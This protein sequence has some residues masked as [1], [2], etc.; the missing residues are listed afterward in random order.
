MWPPP[1]LSLSRSCSTPI[2]SSLYK[3]DW[4]RWK[5]RKWLIQSFMARARRAREIVSQ[6]NEQGK[7]GRISRHATSTFPQF[8]H[9][10]LFHKL[11]ATNLYLYFS[12]L[13]YFFHQLSVRFVRYQLKWMTLFGAETFDLN[14]LVAIFFN[15]GRDLGVEILIDLSV[16]FVQLQDLRKVTVIIYLVLKS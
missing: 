4:T 5:E 10:F 3:W 14:I 12:C 11:Y 7:K 6:E 8:T 13:S 9:F 1:R 16:G 2:A 15:L